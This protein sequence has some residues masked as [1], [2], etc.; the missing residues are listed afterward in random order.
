[1]AD[2]SEK[3]AD[4]KVS[5]VDI[6][7]DSSIT[8]SNSDVSIS[9]LNDD[10]FTIFI[11][12]IRYSLGRQSYMPHL[13]IDYIIP[14][15][16]KID[17]KSLYVMIRDIREAHSWGNPAIDYPKWS[18]FLSLLEAEYKKRKEQSL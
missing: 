14:W 18:K 8:V 5:L 17:N 6:N 1:M 15:I 2:I 9:C 7:A 13:V 16:P 11:C 4:F 12:A 3:N 10:L